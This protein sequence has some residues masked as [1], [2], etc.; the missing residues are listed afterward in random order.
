MQHA[1]FE[2]RSV[3]DLISDTDGHPRVFRIPAYQR[4]YRWKPAQVTQ[5]LEDVCEFGKRA[6]PQPDEFYCLQPLV[7]KTAGGAYEVVDG[8]QRLTTLL[9]ILR[10]FNE[11]MAPKYRS[12]HF[13][14][15]YETRPE[16]PG[17][18]DE[19]SSEEAARN[20]DFYYLHQAIETIEAWFAPRE[21]EFEGFKSTLLNKTRV[22]WYELDDKEDAVDAFTRLNVGKIPLTNDELI[23]ALFLRQSANSATSIIGEQ[24]QIAHE[25]DQLEKALQNDAFWYFLNGE[26][27]ATH[28]RIGF[29]FSLV[30]R[31]EAESN[32]EQRYGVFHAYSRRL[33]LPGANAAREWLRV[34]QV[35]MQ[36]EEWF[37][38][39]SLYHIIGFLVLQGVAVHSI[40]RWAAQGPKAE[41][42]S[43]L[44]REAFAR[45]IG[46]RLE[47]S[48]SQEQL[49]TEL[50]GFLQALEY[51]KSGAAKIR[52]SLLLFNLASLLRSKA[53]NA[54][55]PF[56]SFKKESWDIEHIRSVTSSPP[57][58]KAEQENWLRHAGPQLRAMMLPGK[59]Y[60]EV[61]AYLSAP[62]TPS[63]DTFN[64]LYANVL[65]DFQENQEVDDGIANLTLLDLHTNRSYKNAVFAVKRNHILELDKAGVF[66]PLC[67]RNVFLKGYSQNVD[68]LL[69]WSA[70]DSNGYFNAL[71]EALVDFF[72]QAQEGIV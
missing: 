56:D 49:E 33:A 5:L 20:V 9:L 2:T 1:K 55:F 30:A 37:E 13:S 66:V 48:I 54:R 38:D 51:G 26:K 39:R 63:S 19:P 21:Q 62:K 67:T 35:F 59:R 16:L 22:I 34:K 72:S 70:K 12:K 45:L 53:S 3:Y 7:L 64:T 6:D 18:L 10:H 57:I 25:W 29:L 60:E 71:L 24:L 36:I 15:S 41:F 17:F 61:E 69:F 58:D 50:R 42:E 23:R 68:H 46:K 44:R 11:R 65:K 4:G 31:L 43:L 27:G 32:L 28:N 40:L 52:A 47:A 14:L 8:Q